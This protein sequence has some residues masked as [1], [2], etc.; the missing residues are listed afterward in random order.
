[1]PKGLEVHQLEH[2]P[3]F[4]NSLQHVCYTRPPLPPPHIA[5]PQHAPSFGD[6][7][8]SHKKARTKSENK[9]ENGADDIRNH[10]TKSK[11]K[12]GKRKAEIRKRTGEIRKQGGRDQKT[13]RARSEKRAD[14]NQKKG[15]T[16]IRKQNGRRR[17]RRRTKKRKRKKR[18]GAGI[19]GRRH[20]SRL[21][22][23]N[24]GLSRFIAFR[25]EGEGSWVLRFSVQGSSFGDESRV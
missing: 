10:R 17:Q 19:R 5:I 12:V 15:R 24:R 3:S 13:G 2:P 23:V 22:L 21:P 8:S 11:V 6:N 14:E 20:R 18:E 4:D 9:F 1:M 25:V 7:D 16:I